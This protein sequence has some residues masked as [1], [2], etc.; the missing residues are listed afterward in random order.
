[1]T[2]EDAPAFEPPDF[3]VRPDPLRHWRHLAP[4]RTG[5][6]DVPA[7]RR[8]SY[9]ELDAAA[10]RWAARLEADGV[11]RGDRVAVLARDRVETV[12]L[13]FACGR[14]AAILVP[15][16]W[17]LAPRELA[18]VLADARP[19]VLY[20]EEGYRET[21]RSATEAAPEAVAEVPRVDLD[22]AAE[23]PPGA[24][25][26]REDVPVAANDP[27]MI[28][29]TSGSTGRPKGVVVPRRQVLYNAVATTTAWELG[30]DDVAPI[31]TPL[32]HTGGWHTFATPLWHVGG[33]VVR[34]GSFDP[35][36]FLGTLADTGC[37]VTLTVPTQLQMLR[38]GAEW[39]RPLPGFRAF[40]CGGAAL[41][42]P[43]FEACRAAGYPVREGYGLTE[44]GPNCFAMEPDA[45]ERGHG[46][47][48]RPVPFLEMRLETEEGREPAP[49]EPGEL[50]LRG[51]QMFGGYF[52][53]PERTAEAVTPDGW[54]RTGDLAVR[55]E[56]G[57]Y[58]IRGRKKE[59]YI[60]GGE[61]V[62]PG[63]VEAALAGCPGVAAVAVVGVPHERWG[64]VGRA[65]LVAEP[66]AELSVDE[67]AGWAGE[68]LAGY[69]VPK[70]FVVLEE[71]PRLG[72]GKVDRSALASRAPDREGAP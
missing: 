2:G 55:S 60:S 49:G 46:W 57:I 37:T 63:E 15:L 12:H 1:M 28:L 50:L 64:E 66:D 39:G 23:A 51:P 72:S 47:V 22:E 7:G 71:L 26:P 62:Y 18:G 53:D 30:P 42:E 59:M 41:P 31:S 35:D 10:D 11:G 20:V 8:W 6:L 44:C 33:T 17:R 32:F 21:A 69:K 5:L 65:F 34:I 56:E 3:P 61:N 68:R 40:F 45:W 4:E 48:G 58:A 27:H 70:S 14:T 67:V 9:A 19:T 54:L 25:E 29:Y 43:L 16:N 52:R 36:R 13:Y 38:D 24:D